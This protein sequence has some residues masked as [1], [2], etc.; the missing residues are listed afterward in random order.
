MSASIAKRVD[1]VA[2]GCGVD[3]PLDIATAL[4]PVRSSVVEACAGSGKT[5]LLVSRMLRLL[6]AGAAP[7]ELL[8]ITFTRKAAQEMTDRLHDW[9][10]LL[11]LADDATVREF[12]R[13]R[14]VPE[15]EIDAL[16][17][18]ARGLLETVLTAQPG[19]TV[20]TFH[21]WFLD[22]LKRAPLE[23]GLPWGTPLL[24]REKQLQG[25]VR[26][27][28]LA[29][30][31]AAPE[32]PEGAALLAL[33]AD[34]G[35]H[36]LRALL[37]H[38]LQA[39]SE[40]WAVTDGQPD[41]VAYAL[42]QLR[43]LL[44]ADLDTDP[45]AA[46]WADEEM[47][48]R[49]ERVGLALAK[50]SDAERR[51][52]T[53]ILGAW[54]EPD[55]ECL[56]GLI[57]KKDGGRRVKKANAPTL[58]A[59]G[60]EADRFLRDYETL[61]SGFERI[62][63]IQTDQRIWALN[64]HGLLLGHALLQGYQD[65]K[66]QQG[67]IDFADAEWL[68]CRLLASEEHAPALALKLD[69]RYRHLLLDEFQ[70]TNPLQWQ[71]LSTWLTEARGAD[72]DM[73]VFMVGDPKQAIYR[74]RRGEARV[75]TAAA[76]FLRSHFGAPLFRTSMTRRLAPA[77]VQALNPVFAGID[78]FAP[79]VHAPAN[80]TRP[81]ALRCLPIQVEKSDPAATGSLRNPLTT[82][83]AE[84]DDK[85]V[86]VEAQ[87]FAEVLRNEILDRWNVVDESPPPQPSPACGRGGVARPMRP[88]RAGDV[89][90]LVRRR[91]HLHL[92]ERALEAA[93]I[94]FI[95]S[96]RGGLLHALEARDLIALLDTLLLPRAE[97]KLA[98]VLKSPLF[99]CSDADL[100]RVFIPSPTDG[101]RGWERL[102]ALAEQPDCPSGL[103]RAARLLGRWQAHIG[104]LPVHDLLD[105]IY[106]EGDLEARYAAAAPEAMRPQIG[107]NLRAFMQLALTQDAGRYPTLAGFIR[108]L[109]SLT[110]DVDAAPGEGLAADGENAVRLLTIHGAKGLEAPIVWLL[111]GNDHARGDSYTVLAPWPPEAPQPVHFSLVGRQAERGSSREHWLTEEAELAQRES[112][113]LLYVA[114]TRA[115]QGLIV[116]GAADRNAWLQRVDAAWQELPLPTD[117]PPA[118]ASDEP[119]P[120]SPPPRIAAPAIGQR[121][122][123][124]VANPA[125][126]RGELFHACLEQHAPPGA[127]RDLPALATH[128]GLA[129]ELS[130]IESA[131]R[132]L[133]AQPRLAQFF[134]PARYRRAFNELALLDADGRTQRLDRVVEFADA[135][136]LID[137]KTGDDNRG[138][139]DVQLAERH[140]PQ[141]AA[142]RTMLGGLYPDRPVRAALLLSD[143]RL[144]DMDTL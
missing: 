137:Y 107:A 5:W 48:A 98:H 38:F 71:A 12:L 113:N 97:L 18:R 144:V 134:D 74:F 135:V 30:W 81:G 140:R 35:E 115:E 34:I 100:L 66:A 29:R 33:L 14:A 75:F 133:L 125:A 77:V 118:A 139:S 31:A 32:S 50:G 76:A 61:E 104:M 19:P 84:A 7:S 95:S 136:W 54:A 39:R 6:L 128:L 22:L 101:I 109:A 106:F 42:T 56:R 116:S 112:D 105:R 90:A 103:A 24:E 93:G 69:A 46:F 4:S 129:A 40:W 60:A 44:H 2:R 122:P 73:T 88:A 25:E 86:H 11:A 52:G 92:Y 28:L 124:P 108:E 117:L 53:A 9:L 57:L 3:E 141:L 36:N 80:E 8:A 82:P 78:G 68:A 67:V 10:R 121:L 49:V 65:A 102:T 59:M 96:R 79:H 110:D 111:G 1:C 131:A 55:F 127:R 119:C 63:A 37:A 43:L 23:A 94:P 47:T 20:T 142:Y 16:L 130:R 64:R 15:A 58:K 87:R 70:D 114:L 132:G 123:P 21:G 126:A 89:M 72:S 27:S 120:S 62:A 51:T 41:P 143:G 99:S 83:R 26:D 91:T 85:A 13:E 17:P 45:V 138:L